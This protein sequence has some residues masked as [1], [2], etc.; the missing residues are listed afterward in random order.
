MAIVWASR[1]LREPLPV[2]FRMA[3]HFLIAFLENVTIRLN[4]T[5]DIRVLSHKTPIEFSVLDHVL[6]HHTV[7]DLALSG[8][9]SFCFPL[10]RPHRHDCSGD[11]ALVPL[12]FMNHDQRIGERL[13]IRTDQA[14]IMQRAKQG[15]SHSVIQTRLWR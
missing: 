1:I 14:V 12:A 4:H 3:R 7:A 13:G 15:A 2:D 8:H 10:A 5:A 9:E 11:S 6:E